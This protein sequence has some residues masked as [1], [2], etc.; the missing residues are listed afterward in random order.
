MT[1]V[2]YKVHD[3]KYEMSI[4]GHAGY[5]E[6]GKDI[7]CA[8]VSAIGYALL[9]FLRNTDCKGLRVITDS[10]NL[11]VSCKGGE[12]VSAAF[13]MAYIG[14]LQIAQKYPQYVDCHIVAQGD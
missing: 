4:Y 11:A 1:V 6:A 2:R 5:A 9:G 13:E 8:G 10:G 12:R 7:V 3:G 14:L